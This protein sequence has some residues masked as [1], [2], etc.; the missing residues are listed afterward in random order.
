M[1]IQFSMIVPI[2]M[3]SAGMCSAQ[4]IL[5][6]DDDAASG[7]DGQSWA[8]AYDDLQSALGVA[9]SG[10]EIWIAQGLYTP[11]DGDATASF[12]MINGV[13]IYGGF[14]GDETARDQR[15]PASNITHLSGDVGRDDTFEPYMLNTSNAGHVIVASGVSSNTVID[16]VTIEFG[17]YGPSGTPAGDP[18]MFGSGIYCIGGSP[19]I[20]N[21]V[22]QFNYTAFAAGGGA[23]FY[24]SNPTITNTIFLGNYAH[25]SKGAGLFLGGSS[26]AVIEDCQFRYNTIVFSSPDGAGGGI[27]HDSTGDLLVRRSLFEGNLVRP[28]Y[29]LGDDIGYG[30][31][32]FSF[33]APL[34]VE[35]SV[36]R[37]NTA[38]IG[39]GIIAWNEALIVNTLFENN[40]AQAR[41]STIQEL[42]GF[43]GGFCSYSFVARDMILENCTFV[44]NHGKE[45]GGASGG[46]NSNLIVNNCIFFGNT[47]WNP[48]FQ[49]YYREEI[50][51]S[52]DLRYSLIPGI[53]GPPAQGE[54]PIDPENLIGCIDLDPMFVGAGD[55]RLASNSPAIDAGEN[56]G[57]TSSLTTDHDG[58]PRFVDD[59]DTADTGAG[60]SPVIDMGAYEFQVAVLCLADLTGDG[61]LNFFDVSAFLAAF[62]SGDPIADFTGDGGLNFFDVSA[63]LSAFAAGCP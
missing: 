10:D 61:L 42:G 48:E 33:R 56:A 5:R 26:S 46:W 30:G 13:S 12:V 17:A 49:G 6:V 7:G 16:G 44:N 60:P 21:C 47:G 32:I 51:G 8:S 31:G 43:G 11:S 22:I 57:W 52:F 20:N 62:A 14:M 1:S 28:F 24:D 54:D 2:I 29:S 41:E 19:T 37:G 63:F 4:S 36:F 18:L 38:T 58:N 53:F 45:H 39:G 3:I 55:Y 59:P 50:G 25:L 15:D 35:D 40:T 23:Y 27:S 9:T 34:T